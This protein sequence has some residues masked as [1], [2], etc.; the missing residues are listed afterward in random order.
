VTLTINHTL[1]KPQFS[2]VKSKA[3][4]PAFVGGFGSGKTQAAIFRTL[5][6]KLAYPKQNVAYYLPTYDLISQ[7]A[8]PRFSELLDTMKIP[9]Q[10]NRSEKI[11]YLLGGGQIILRT[12]D[13]PERIIGYEVA[14]SVIDELDTLKRD[15]AAEVWRKVVARNRQKKPDQSINTVGVATTPEGFRFVYENWYRTPFANSELIVAS[16]YSNRNNLPD[17]YI[18]QLRDT[19]PSNMLAA[20]LDGQFVNLTQG[21]VYAEFDRHKNMCNTTVETDETLHIGMDFNVGQMAACVHVLRDN[22]PHAVD[23][24]VNYLDTPALIRAIE[25]RY[26]GHRIMAYPDASGKSRRSVNASESDISLL[27]QAKFSV[28]ANSSNP[29]IKDRVAAFNKM[30]YKDG[31]RQYKIN[32]DKCPHLTEG[33]EKQ[34]YDKNGEPDKTSGLDHILDGAG[35]FISY[36]YPVAKHVATQMKLKGL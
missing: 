10:L 16:T 11:I 7:I 15:K 32:V 1:T 4:F 21:S 34:A 19:Y 31:K 8:F 17:G 5:H 33:L 14:D 26:Q 29:F 24:F 27:R 9:F 30:I 2:L 23:E 22:E 13:Q 6:K 20:Y 12:M 28:L 35:Y 3:A 25:N 36:R 18:Q